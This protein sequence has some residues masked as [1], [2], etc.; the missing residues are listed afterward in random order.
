MV[1]HLR[2]RF[3][4]LLS[5]L[6][7]SSGVSKRLRSAGALSGPQYSFACCMSS[8]CTC[9]ANAACWSVH[10]RSSQGVLLCS[11][12]RKDPTCVVAATHSLVGASNAFDA[13]STCDTQA[14]GLARP[15]K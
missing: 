6:S 15:L 14:E 5:L 10:T 9:R 13:L 8:L 4:G 12:Y 3:K 11:P 1:V 7:C 2:R